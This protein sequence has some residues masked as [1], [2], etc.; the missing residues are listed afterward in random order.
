MKYSCPSTLRVFVSQQAFKFMDPALQLAVSSLLLNNYTTRM[1]FILPGL[2][3]P[4]YLDLTVRSSRD[5]HC[6]RIRLQ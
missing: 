2:G 4:S 1:S 6:C 5:A 3:V